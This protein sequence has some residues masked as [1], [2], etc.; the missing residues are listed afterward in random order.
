MNARIMIVSICV[1]LTSAEGLLAQTSTAAEWFDRAAKE[2]VKQDK[3]TALRTLEK[4]LKEHPGDVAMT[5]LAEALLKGEDPLPKDQQQQQDQQQKED[6]KKE[7][8][9]DGNEQKDS[10]KDQKDRPSPDNKEQDQQPKE[11]GTGEGKD[12]EKQPARPAP[13]QIA[14]QD[15]KRM[16]D[17][18]Q[19]SEKDVQ[20]KVR[21][22]KRPTRQTPTDKDW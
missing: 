5:R 13:G 6:E 15:A 14:P 4:G 22:R 3:M 9:K 2:F 7:A 8:G 17:A 1:L 12:G 21:S 11:D 18:L 20:Q 19:R 10:R 16:L